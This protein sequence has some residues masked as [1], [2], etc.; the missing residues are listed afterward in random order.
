[1]VDKEQKT[2]YNA[3]SQDAG[4]FSSGIYFY[5]LKADDFVENRL[6][7]SRSGRAGL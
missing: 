7:V 5:R 1:L 2:G 4:S 6:R 3:V